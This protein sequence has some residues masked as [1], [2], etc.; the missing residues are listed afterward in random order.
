MKAYIFRHSQTNYK[1]GRTS[2]EE[3]NDLTLEGREII[4]Q[5]GLRLAIQLNGDST[6]RILS[7]PFGRCLD[8]AK[9]TQNAF[10]FLEK[11]VDSITP[12]E[13]LREVDNFEWISTIR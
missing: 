7:S 9:T 2:L 8:S 13:G 6:V 3:A 11:T 5:Y 1:Q 12:T 10:S 4:L